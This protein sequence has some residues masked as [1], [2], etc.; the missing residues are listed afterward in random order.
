[1]NEIL[2]IIR[3]LLEK[4]ANDTEDRLED[5]INCYQRGTVN[6]I[7]EQQQKDLEF[8]DSL[9]KIINDYNEANYERK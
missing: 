1:M 6:E 5:L 7:I 8:M 4:E 9:L 2:N 3:L